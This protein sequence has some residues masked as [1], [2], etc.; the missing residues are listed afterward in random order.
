MG[1]RKVVH[2]IEHQSASESMLTHLL[3]RTDD[4]PNQAGPRPG[5]QQPLQ[6]KRPYGRQAC[7]AIAP[8]SRACRAGC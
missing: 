4:L 6:T 8:S 5:Q 7:R 3:L 2:V 1:G